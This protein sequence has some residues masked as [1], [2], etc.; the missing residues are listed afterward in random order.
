MA[1]GFGMI[2][3]TEWMLSNFGRIAFFEQ[4]FGTE[5]GSR[6]G[7]KFIGMIAFFIGLMIF[8]NMIGGLLEWILSPLLQYM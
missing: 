1:A 6:L 2:Y 3:K 4:K 7:W 5:G 8:T